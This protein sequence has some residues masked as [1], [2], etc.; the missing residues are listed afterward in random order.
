AN[1]LMAETR[2]R[3]VLD[4]PPW[5]NTYRCADGQYISVGA[6]EP[7]FY[8]LLREKLGLGPEDPDIPTADPDNWETWTRRFAAIFAQ[9]DRAAWCSLLEGTDA[10]FAPV[11]SPNQAAQHPHMRARGI[12]QHLDGA[13]H[14]APAPRFSATPA[15]IPG[16]VPLRGEHGDTV[17]R[18]WCGGS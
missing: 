9:R 7:R 1:G 15:D 13:L 18:D 17:L 5:Y 8:A 2:G 14:A 12:Y 11:L 4:G 16:A 10:C 3:G 6:V